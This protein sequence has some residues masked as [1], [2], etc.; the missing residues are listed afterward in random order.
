MISLVMQLLKTAAVVPAAVLE[1]LILT[2]LIWAISS[3]IFL[4]IYLAAAE[5]ADVPIMDR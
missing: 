5:E 2:V 1:G 4:A 3:A